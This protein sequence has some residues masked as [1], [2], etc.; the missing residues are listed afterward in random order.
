[1]RFSTKTSFSALALLLWIAVGVLAVGQE[2][3][4]A[5]NS[6]GVQLKFTIQAADRTMVSLT[7]NNYTGRVVVPETVTYA[8]TVRTVTSVGN[9]FANTTVSYVS[10][11]ATV[12]LS[13]GCFSNCNSLDSIRFESIESMTLPPTFMQAGVLLGSFFGSTSYNVSRVTIIVPCGSLSRCKKTLWRAFP[14]IKTDCSHYMAVVPTLDS[15]VLL[16]GVKVSELPSGNG[17][18]NGTSNY[19]SDYYE[20]GDTAYLYH[21]SMKD[22]SGLYLC[23]NGYALGWS[24]G[25]KDNPHHY[26][27]NSYDT[28]WCYADTMPWSM[29]SVNQVTTPVYP[30]GN[31]SYNSANGTAVYYLGQNVSTV[32]ANGLWIGS[33]EHVAATRFSHNP[34]EYSPGPLRVTDAISDLATVSRFNRVWHISRDMIDYHIAHCGEAG[35]VPCDDIKTWPG[36]GDSTA[37]FAAQLAPY[38]DA[39]GDGRYRPLAGDYPLIRGD[40]AVFSIF[41][42]GYMSHGN[43][44]GQPFGVEIHCMVYA[45]NEPDDAP[46]HQTV[47]IDYDIY[48]RSSNSYLETYLGAWADFDIGYGFDDYIGCDVK[49]GMFYGYNGDET[50]GPGDMSFSGNWIPAQGC[51][52]LGGAKLPGDGLDNPKI[53]IDKMR[54]RFPD[55]L[56]GYE[57]S[58]GSYDTVRLTSDAALYYPEAW[59]FTS[60]D[61]MGNYAINGTGFGDGIADNER[62]G[63]TGFV[64]YE[65]RASGDNSEPMK[66]QD[67]YSYLGGYWKNGQHIKYGGNGLSTGISEYDC[68]FMY[69][70]GSDPLNYGTDGVNPGFLWS[71]EQ[72]GNIIGDRRGIGSCGPFAF[73]PNSNQRFN[74]AFVSACG[75]ID[76]NTPSSVDNLIGA[77]ESVQRQWTRDTVDSGRPM[78]YMPYSAPHDVAEDPE[79]PQNGIDQTASDR[80]RLMVYPNPTNGVLHISCSEPQTARLFDLYGREQ[81][82]FTV[83]QSESYLDISSLPKGVYFL[84]VVNSV[85]KIVRQ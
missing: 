2:T 46:I 40:E 31:L 13:N 36:N 52:I 81:M 57:L 67:Y 71:E 39:D 18:A 44:G 25:S 41:N 56:A 24:D 51:M 12:V 62:M 69:P 9:A 43:T 80:I 37:G 78:T 79:D 33:G 85:T 45:F 38:Y 30:F 47:F 68:R 50:D 28:V 34:L 70:G 23:R 16:D 27:V 60:G 10:I 75:Y 48:N 35:Y 65:N 84:R 73:E 72:A 32:F 8:D 20:L 77:A 7:A 66:Y 14:T 64:Y 49:H 22:A 6:E 55:A 15:I 61:T 76:G 63:M 21:S 17:F 82:S 11:P 5:A 26:V 42:D 29:L 3:F 1:M 53:D 59:Y 58:N 83:N 54:V 19:C 4:T 74:I